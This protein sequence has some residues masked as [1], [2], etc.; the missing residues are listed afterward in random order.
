LVRK[1][2]SEY[3]DELKQ[4]MKAAGP[5]MGLDVGA[6]ALI[7]VEGVRFLNSCEDDGIA[8]RNASQNISV[9]GARPSIIYGNG[10]CGLIACWRR[11]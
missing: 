8:I 11:H 3:L 2:R 5:D 10:M 7:S 1:L 9:D 4:Q 6:V